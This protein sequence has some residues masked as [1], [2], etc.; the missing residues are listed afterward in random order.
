MDAPAAQEDGLPPAQRRRAVLAVMLVLAQAVLLAAQVNVALPG[1][2]RDLAADP[3]A[4]VWIVNAYQ[5]AVVAT[6]L[7]FAALGDRIGHRRVFLAGTA[8]FGLA[9]AAC[10]LAPSLPLLIAARFVQ[11]LGG[12]A[13]MSVQPALLRFSYPHAQLGR[14]IGNTAMVVAISTAVGPSAAAALLAVADWPWMFLVNL[15]LALLGLALG[16]PA[17]PRDAATRSAADGR[18]DALAALLNA[19]AFGLVFVGLYALAARPVLGVVALCGGL[20]AGAAL[21]RRESGAPAPLLPLD[22]LRVPAIGL[23][24][25]ASV[26]NFAGQ[27]TAFVA[28]PFLLQHDLGRDQ[29]ETGLL[30]TPWAVAVALVAPLAGRLSD[31]FS[32]ATL[33]AIGGALTATGLALLAALPHAAGTAGF[34]A[35]LALAGLGFGLFQTPNN[36]AML[37]AA[38]R[39]RSGG[40]GGL[41]GTARLSGQTLGST[42]VGLTFLAVPQAAPATALALGACFALAGGAVSLGRRL[43]ADRPVG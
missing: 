23:A 10:A 40:A 37:G 19:A 18:F 36:R 14:A 28:L 33:C 6:M 41:Q 39:A 15:P 38:P 42:V 31:R 27:M 29:V 34:V 24:V 5:L 2:A 32:T 12:A 30:I 25:A 4:T 9:S 7:P 1:I 43:R 3:A 35:L 13:T 26:C 16:A 20:A 21:V 11:G 8:A 22:L 17:L